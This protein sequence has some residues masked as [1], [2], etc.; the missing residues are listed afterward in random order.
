[1]VKKGLKRFCIIVV[2]TTATVTMVLSS[3]ARG[4]DGDVNA[5][6]QSR[7]ETMYQKIKDTNNG[8]FSKDGVPY[9]SVETLLVEAPDYGHVTTSE[10]FS[11]YMWLE[12]V[13]GRF[14]GD[15][16]GFQKSWDTAEKYIIP[17]DKDQPNSSMSKYKPSAPAS[18]A[19]EW[20]EPSKYPAQLDFDAPVGT[21]P[22]NREL[23]SAY[24]T[25]MIYGMHWLLD[26][27]NWYGYGLRGD[28]TS[29]NSYINTF[30]RGAQESTWETIPQPCYDD[31]IHVQYRLLTGQIHG[32]RKQ[33][34]ILRPMFKKLPKW[35]TI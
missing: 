34:Q 1:M 24:G 15:F 18:Y 25:N 20:E 30:Q 11:Y 16:T 17:S 13:N 21:D 2:A 6:Y 3:A 32:R 27:D 14:T 22:I 35:V 10:A 5:E 31:M 7:F 4:A 23:V 19:P 28:G 26:V 29:K 12:A 33:E 9:H 8:Y